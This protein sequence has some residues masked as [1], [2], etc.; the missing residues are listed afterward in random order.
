MTKKMKIESKTIQIPEERIK[1]D[2]KTVEKKIPKDPSTLKKTSDPE[3]NSYH[4]A[5]FWEGEDVPFSFIC[6][7]FDAVSML[8]GEN[9][10][11]KI[12]DTL[13][14]MFRSIILL[15]PDQLASTYYFCIFRISPEYEG[16][17]DIGVGGGTLMKAISKTSGRSEKAL[18]QHLKQVGDLGVVAALSKSNQSNITTFFKKGAKEIRLTMKQVMDSF[19]RCSQ[20]RGQNSNNEREKIMIKL[21]GDAKNT[22]PTYLVRY[23]E[24]NFRIGALE[25]T[26][27]AALAKAFLIWSHSDEKFIGPR[28]AKWSA[29]IPGYEAKLQKFNN[30]IERAI[31]EFPNHD[32]LIDGLLKVGPEIDALLQICKIRPGVPPKAMLAQPTKG[33]H[34]VFKRFE[35]LKFTCEYKYDGLRGQI[36]YFDGKCVI[37][38]RRLENLTESYPDVVDR[39]S[40]V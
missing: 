28:K 29:L 26:M 1:I 31:N 38:S 8:K 40:V 27:Q 30:V 5:P 19:R 13:S 25:L 22:E 23:F 12:I 36:H 11:E 7:T 15:K 17:N 6:E 20:L 39:K 16:K 34:V 32:V 33:V 37:Y 3:Y 35:N 9:S 14:N 2:V 21:F 18:F 10:K 24:R 4:D